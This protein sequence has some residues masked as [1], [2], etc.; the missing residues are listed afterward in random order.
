MK[1]EDRP[2]YSYL[3]GLLRKA[4]KN[5]HLHFDYNKFDWIVKQKEIEE[6]EKKKETEKNEGKE[7]EKVKKEIN[8]DEIS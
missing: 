4:A 5:N 2:D 7:E 6:E 8:I 1:F 3:R